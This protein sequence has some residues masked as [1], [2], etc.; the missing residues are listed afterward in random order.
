MIQKEK[1]T[2]AWAFLLVR[3]WYLL[4]HLYCYELA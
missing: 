1:P 2:Y 4:L 3:L